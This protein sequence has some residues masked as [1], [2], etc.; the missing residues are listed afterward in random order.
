MNPRAFPILNAIGCLALTGLVIAQWRKERSLDGTL[1]GVK[2][3]LVAARNQAAEDAKQR[4]ALER[5]IAV[6]K[7]SIES[8]QQAAE[9]SARTLAEKD[10]LATQLQTELSTARE[11][12][13]AWETALKPATSG[14]SPSTPISPPPAGASKRPSPNSK[15]P[16][17]AEA[18]LLLTAESPKSARLPVSKKILPRNPSW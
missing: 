14:S 16:V 7:E 12:V 3:E 18:F 10:Q 1:A 6:L 13:I 17:H 2:S 11:Q 8:T 9:T 15:P 5:D 4:A